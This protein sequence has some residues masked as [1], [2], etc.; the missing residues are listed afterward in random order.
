M[1]PHVDWDK[2]W[3]MKDLLAIQDQRDSIHFK[4]KLNPDPSKKPSVTYIP[5]VKSR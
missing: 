4:A 2:S 1:L 5:N 3:P